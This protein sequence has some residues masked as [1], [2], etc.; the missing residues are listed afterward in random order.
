[1]GEKYFQGE[2]QKWQNLTR[3][4]VQKKRLED[5]DKERKRREKEER[6]ALERIIYD[7]ENRLVT[8]KTYD[9]RSNGDSYLR[10]LSEAGEVYKVVRDSDGHIEIQPA[11]FHRDS[12]ATD[13]YQQLYPA[14]LTDRGSVYIASARQGIQIGKNVQNSR[15]V[16]IDW[17]NVKSVS[18]STF[19]VKE[20]IKTKGFRWDSLRKR[21]KK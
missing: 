12:D 15:S 5:A 14:K 2:W 21:W 7:D 20:F 10:D 13:A 19:Y 16:G 4:N 11:N 1:M 6:D 3:R 17:D 18:G 9:R 8:Y